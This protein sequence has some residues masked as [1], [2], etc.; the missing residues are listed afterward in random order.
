[1]PLFRSTYPL[2]ICLRSHHDWASGHFLRCPAPKVRK[3]CRRHSPWPILVRMLQPLD[4]VVV[5][6]AGCMLR[7]PIRHLVPGDPLV[8]YAPTDLAL[9]S[10][11]LLVQGCFRLPRLKGVCLTWT[12]LLKGICLARARLVVRHTHDRGLLT[13]GWCYRGA[14]VIFN[15]LLISWNSCRRN[16]VLRWTSAECAFV[17]HSHIILITARISH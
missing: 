3:G 7:P 13:I 6:L 17:A 14:G 16:S 4:A 12:R 10:G 15:I 9:D 1:L 2:L 8:R 5:R 11:L